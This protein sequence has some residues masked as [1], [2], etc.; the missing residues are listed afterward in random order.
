MEGRVIKILIDTGAS[1]NYIANLNSLRGEI[2]LTNYFLVESV[3]GKTM[4]T[5]KYIMNIFNRRTWFYN[6]PDLETFDGIVGYDF[7]KEIK[8]K[9]DVEKGV[10]EYEGGK[11][12]LKYLYSREINYAF[13]EGIETTEKEYLIGLENLLN[14]YSNVFASPNEALPFNTRVTAT[15][16]TETDEPIYCSARPY[17]LSMNDFVN[18]EIRELLRNNII[19]PSYSPYNSPVLVVN[20]KGVDEN[21]LPKKRMVID[22][23]KLNSKTTADRYPIPNISVI[24]ANLGTG[25]FFTT[26]DLKSGYHQINLAEKDRKK[27]AFSI[28]N[29]KYEFC[30]LPFGLKN[31]PGIFQRAV[32]D[33]LRD[34][35]G[36]ICHVYVDDI[37]IF[38]Q[39][40]EKHLEDIERILNKLYVANM[41]ISKEKS[42][43]FAKSVEYL[44]FIVSENGISTHPDKI[45][46]IL[47]FQ[48][49]TSLR[50]LRSF[51]GLA[52]YYR[53][54]VKDYSQIAKP[55]TKFLGGENGNVSSRKSKNVR[56]DL[57]DVEIET[58]EKLKQILASEDVLLLHPD[59]NEPFDLTTDASSFAIGAVLSQKGRP[60]TMISRTLSPAESKY[61]TNERELL[62]IVWAIRKLRNYLYGTKNLNIYTDHQPLTFSTSTKNPNPIISKWKA[63][64][65]EYSPK[66]FYKPGKEN[67]VADA[68]SRQFLNILDDNSETDTASEIEERIANN[69][70]NIP[71]SS[72][73]DTASEG[74]STQNSSS[75]PNSDTA[76]S[77]SSLTEVIKTV[78]NPVNCFKNQIILIQGS[79]YNVETKTPFEN[80]TRHYV[81]F[82]NIN[83]IVS[84]FK[85]FLN[86]TVKN[87]IHCELSILGKIQQTLVTHFP[88]VK[89]LH[90][91]KFVADVLNKDDQH[92]ILV[93]EHN[94]AHR[95]ALENLNQI[96]EDYYF[97]NIK[98]NLIDI[99]KNCKVC[100]E[101]KYERRPRKTEISQTPI[102]S[103]P[104]EILHLDI[105]ATDRK[106]FLTCIDKFS[107]FAIVKNIQSRSIVDIKPAL[108]EMLNMF[109]GIKTIICDNEKSLNSV[110][111]KTFLKNNFDAVIFAVPPLHS[112]TNGQVERF[113]STLTEIAR[114]IRLEQSSID[115]V[116]LV[117]M[118]TLKYNR[119]IH[120]TIKLRPIDVVNASSLDFR[121]RIKN[122]LI[123]KQRLDLEY[124]NRS[125]IRRQFIPGDKV[126]VKVN[127]RLGNKFS[128]IYVEKVV[129][130]DL[131][132]TVR[133]DNRI[134]HKDNIR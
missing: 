115:T 43:F 86:P 89:I 54:F 27:T 101:A 12:K 22:F 24:L 3:H 118:A 126:F 129:Q 6:L 96:L 60:I 61:A 71:L 111:I 16:K 47:N 10:L 5:K 132:T 2:P 119:S 122:R 70:A 45:K 75:E 123:S 110:T 72:P 40:A 98:K 76:H 52:S 23:R 112:S 28:N 11:E 131:G 93:N 31:A 39:S 44:G 78:Q 62:A 65:E 74:R 49:P 51:L 100:H 91:N 55:L 25:K 94:R 73:T 106:Y 42:N 83:D 21:G 7:L 46:D 113:H 84:N 4:I 90:T 37:I 77:E 108:Y 18:K 95:S 67:V 99:I 80:R 64:I 38:S 120:S 66:F 102:P 20:K 68:L 82:T 121:N 104:G 97:P 56:I 17:P 57:N 48:I 107:K 14:K 33:I 19:R 30:R 103:Y 1:K 130:E 9:I 69:V 79:E 125:R 92:E 87:A 34:E 32:D 114:C 134:V 133:I 127:K 85:N 81:T 15:I 58:F 29:G 36:K 35:V 109:K 88:S 117:L 63:A 41:R 13:D 128:K 124:H 53:R 59:F 8:A 50:S 116:E 105:Y 26:L